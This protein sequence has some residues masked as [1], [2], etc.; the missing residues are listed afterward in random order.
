MRDACS[1]A[2]GYHGVAHRYERRRQSSGR[3]ATILTG[4]RMDDRKTRKQIRLELKTQ[5]VRERLGTAQLRQPPGFIIIGAQKGGTTSLYHYLTAHPDVGEALKKEVHYFD[6]H[7]GEGP[8]W[9]LAHFPL[10]GE[11]ALTG[12][13]SP[14]YL[15][16]PEAPRRARQMVP[17]VKLIALL[18]N[19]VDRA[20]SQHQMNVTV[21]IEW[22]TFEE[23]MAQEAERLQRAGH[24]VP[25]GSWR[26]YSYV[27]RGLYAE[28]LQRWLT[29]FPCEQLLVLKSEDFFQRPEESYER[30]LAFLGLRPWR[31]PHYQNHRPGAYDAMRPETR[32]RLSKYFAPHN[33]RLYELLGQ[34]FGWDEPES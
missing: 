18:R 29:C 15:F 22:L 14:S 30:A 17:Q 7:Y 26:R 24:D 4:L 28:Q 21:G 20:Y 27:G 6:Y 9:Y 8:D 1:S 19:P 33:Q 16:H 10:G 34:D 12:E 2:G 23:A 5:A 13:A 3:S 25:N 11:A 31:L 32:V